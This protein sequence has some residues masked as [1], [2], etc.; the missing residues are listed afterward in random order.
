MA[1]VRKCLQIFLP[2]LSSNTEDELMSSLTYSLAGSSA[3]LSECC[4]AN[5]FLDQIVNGKPLIYSEKYKKFFKDTFPDVDTLDVV[6]VEVSQIYRV[7][8][9]C[10]QALYQI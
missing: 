2:D 6:P 5:S 7:S 1:V 3:C 8:I 4:T 10:C 9:K